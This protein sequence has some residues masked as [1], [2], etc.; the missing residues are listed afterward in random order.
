MTAPNPEI[1]LG[2]ARWAADE[3]K[4]TIDHLWDQAHGKRIIT[5]GGPLPKI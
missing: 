1:G 4:R 5:A 2:M 3:L